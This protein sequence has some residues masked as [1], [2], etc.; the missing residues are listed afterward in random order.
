MSGKPNRLLPC[1]SGDLRNILQTETEE[2]EK[3]VIGEN[4]VKSSVE[5]EELFVCLTIVIMSNPTSVTL[6]P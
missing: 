3:Q 1:S 6:A 5:A 2:E 4:A